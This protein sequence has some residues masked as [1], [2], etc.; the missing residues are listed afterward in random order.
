MVL[1]RTASYFIVANRF[2]LISVDSLERLCCNL[3]EVRSYITFTIGLYSLL[4]RTVFHPAQSDNE[5]AQAR[6]EDMLYRTLRI[7]A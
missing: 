3:C 1:V 2:M 6:A 4:L 5:Y 7:T